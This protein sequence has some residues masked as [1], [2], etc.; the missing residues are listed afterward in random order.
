MFALFAGF[1]STPASAQLQDENL[2]A[3]LPSGFKLGFQTRQG[4]MIMM[5]YVPVDETVEDW[6]RMVT[7]Q[8][9]LG[10]GGADP[11]DFARS[12]AGMWTTGC[13]GATAREVHSADENGYPANLLRLTC[14]LNAATGKPENTWIKTMAGA[15][16]LYVVQMA[17]ATKVA[18]DE[19]KI[20]EDYL[21]GV[22]ICDTRKD[23]HPC[24]TGLTPLTPAAPR[25]QSQSA[26]V[27]RGQARPG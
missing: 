5:E 7:M 27:E 15:D 26:P 12:I 3:T 11:R 9:F 19:V 20:A 4:K 14:P 21:N 16:A 8:V 24:P 23:A 1:N 25:K 10:S 13:P 22:S 6:S 17:F 2:I 18:D